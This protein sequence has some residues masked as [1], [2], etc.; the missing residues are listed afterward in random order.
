MTETRSTRVPAEEL[1]ERTAVDVGQIQRLVQAGA[2][3]PDDHG[4]F[5]PGDVH[6]VRLLNAFADAGI[7]TDAVLAAAGAGS[8]SF[9]YYPQFHP[10]P[11][12]LSEHTYRDFALSRGD[13]ASLLPQLFAAFGL[14]EPDPATR[15]M[16]E[17]EEL[18]GQMLDIIVATGQ[19]DL[20]FRV[21]RL[22]GEA[23]RRSIDS[24]VGIYA[25]A[26]D[27]SGHDSRGLPSTDELEGLL[28]VWAVFATRVSD[29]MAWLTS[30]HLVRAIDDYTVVETER[31]LERAGFVASRLE[32]APPAVAFVDLSEFT[33]MTEERGDDAAAEMAL[34]LG[35]VT[36]NAVTKRNGRVVKLLGDGVLVRFDDARAAVDGAL[37]LLDAM[38]PSGLPA[39]HA[40]VASG[41]LVMRDGDVFGRT[42]NLAA[43]IADVAPRGRLYVPGAVRSA[44]EGAPFNVRPTKGVVLRGIGQID[45]FDVSRA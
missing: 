40:G 24:A 5:D 35:E 26:V 13:G 27:R 20:A 7:P 11:G 18:I 6:L 37:D 16:R 29:L 36:V 34:R 4:L 25:E 32:T 22:F 28:R 19:P 44:V 23:A 21:V 31:T 41:P 8:I 38:P 45:L 42:V 30:R 33:R 2:I 14:A 12:P 15:L 43:R 1:S 17:D 10:P 39:G 3:S 9:A